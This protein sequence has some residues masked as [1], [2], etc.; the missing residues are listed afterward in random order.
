MK[1]EVC[2]QCEGE[3]MLRAN[4]TNKKGKYVLHKEVC[5]NCRGTGMENLEQS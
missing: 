1:E 5:D 4:Y 3:G 2:Y